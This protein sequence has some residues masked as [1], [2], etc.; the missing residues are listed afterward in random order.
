M[1]AWLFRVFCKIVQVKV[2]QN[3]LHQITKIK[4]QI[5]EQSD[6]LVRVRTLYG[7]S[8][9]VS[10]CSHTSGSW[11][12]HKSAIFLSIGKDLVKFLS[13]KLHTT[14]IK[15]S[16]EPQKANTEKRRKTLTDTFS[17]LMF[18]IVALHALCP[19]KCF[20]SKMFLALNWFPVI[21]SYTD[22]MASKNEAAWPSGLGR[23]CC[24]PEVLGSR[25]PPCH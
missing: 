2:A 7:C 10:Q 23:W 17:Q 1:T 20:F 21:Q 19:L 14:S 24:N 9:V 22:N 13:M 5:S 11:G 16:I 12:C 3:E 4:Q 18:D 25:P 6:K 8:C 15:L